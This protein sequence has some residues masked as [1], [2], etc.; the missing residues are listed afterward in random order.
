MDHNQQG[1]KY[2]FDFSSEAEVASYSNLVLISHSPNDFVLDFAQ[3]MPGLNRPVVGKRI[4]MTPEHTK[5]LFYALQENIQKYEK[6]FG[7]IEINKTGGENTISP[8]GNG[9]GMA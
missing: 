8:F 7:S 6:E 3:M 4:V 9:R 2:P 5:R 1:A